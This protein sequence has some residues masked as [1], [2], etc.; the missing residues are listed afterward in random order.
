MAWL[1]G[2]SGLVA[3]DSNSDRVPVYYMWQYKP[4][5]ARFHTFA[6][7]NA[8]KPMGQVLIHKRD[9]TYKTL[10]CTKSLVLP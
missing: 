3:M 10:Y 1:L 4:G 7:I 8:Q 6:T 9:L 2:Y 5:D